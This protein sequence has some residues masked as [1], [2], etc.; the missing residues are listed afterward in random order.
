[1][2]TR[3][4]GRSGFVLLLVMV[5]MAVGSAL[6]MSTMND[7]LTETATA[8][9]ATV[10]RRA[11][12]AAETGAWMTLEGVGAA[13][14]RDAPLGPLST[15]SRTVG[16]MLLTA[17]VDKVDT[18][19]VWIVSTAIVRQGGRVVARHRIGISALIP[20]DTADPLLHRLPERAWAELF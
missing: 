19:I 4:T 1:M 8:R 9:S 7:S 13:A 14:L 17:T 20:L 10:R 3:V 2:V 18:T 12:V 16:D 11:L 15:S 5:L 6:M